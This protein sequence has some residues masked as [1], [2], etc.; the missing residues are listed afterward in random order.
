MYSLD[1][2]ETLGGREEM[3]R[4]EVTFPSLLVISG[5]ISVKRK[6]G[7]RKWSMGKGPHFLCR[8]SLSICTQRI[9]GLSVL[10]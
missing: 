3:N 7:A 8:N 5:I 4:G 1:L 2:R 10:L 9:A 6:T